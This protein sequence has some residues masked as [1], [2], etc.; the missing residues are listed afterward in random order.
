MVSQYLSKREKFQVA[1][2]RSAE[3]PRLVHELKWVMDV[4]LF[5]EL[6]SSW[7]EDSPHRLVILHEM[8]WHAAIEGQKEVEQTICQGHWLHM[9][10]LNLEA[11]VPIV[12]LMG[13]QTTKEELLDL[14]LEVYKLH[15]Q[16][17]SPPRK[18]AILDKIMA[19]VLDHPPSGGARHVR[20][21]PS[22][23]LGA[24]THLGAVPP[25]SRGGTMP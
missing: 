14:Y 24:P 21:Q 20:P 2:R 10:Q 16:P 3:E 15:R 25:T 22:L 4:K 1:K 13:P 8:F 17:G 9:P 7:P 11:G 19:T 5:L 12:Q 23:G 6:Q 18:L